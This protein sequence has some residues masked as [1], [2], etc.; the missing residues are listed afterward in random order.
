MPS[1]PSKKARAPAA[2]K[3][4]RPPEA[5]LPA[6]EQAPT[7]ESE[8]RVINVPDV[9]TSDED[10][11]MSSESQPARRRRDAGVC[12]YLHSRECRSDAATMVILLLLVVLAAE[13]YLHGHGI[14]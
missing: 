5:V 9:A 14:H 3:T 7:S 2:Q 11:D 4:P 10:D 6:E 12:S 1:K 8:E 13:H